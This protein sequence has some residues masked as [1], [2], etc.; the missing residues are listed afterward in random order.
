MHL[1]DIPYDE[2]GEFLS[3]PNRFL[4]RVLL[5]GREEEAHLHDPGRLPDLV[6]PG[7]PLAL[8][9]AARPGRRTRW[10]VLAVRICGYWCFCHSG[11][12]RRVAANLLFLKRPFGEFSDFEAEPRAG[13]GRLDFKL[14][15]FGGPLW[16]EVKGVTWARGRT[17]LF[18]D[19]PTERGLRH[20][21]TLRS[22][23]REGQRAGLLFLVFR[24]E[25]E[26]V[27]P[28]EEIQPA[29]AQALREALS[30]GLEA[31]AFVLTYDGRGIFL[32][33]EIPVRA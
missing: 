2:E 11:Y 33:R 28:A 1:L 4:V 14:E 19:A 9:Y 3:R 24:K 17:A 26:E 6:Q 27:R 12:H 10:D 25:A 22:F 15:T 18:P 29:F 7:R 20:L 31:R 23:L 5:K 13:Q 30:E 21:Q 8:R 32:A 16:L